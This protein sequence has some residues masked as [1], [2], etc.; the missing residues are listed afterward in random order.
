MSEAGGGN[1]PEGSEGFIPKADL[2][3]ALTSMGISQNAATR[4]H[5]NQQIKN[6]SAA[7][8]NPVAFTILLSIPG[9]VLHWEL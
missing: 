4:V 3:E 9:F 5:F 2:L 6:L 7:A 8:E 1:A